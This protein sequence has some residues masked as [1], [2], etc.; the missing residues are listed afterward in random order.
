M[1]KMDLLRLPTGG[2][3]IV[4]SYYSWGY[5]IGFSAI[6]LLFYLPLAKLPELAKT[7]LL[8]IFQLIGWF[9]PVSMPNMT[10]Q[11]FSSPCLFY[12]DLIQTIVPITGLKLLY[13]I[14]CMELLDCCYSSLTS[15]PLC[16][17]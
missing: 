13:G 15:E 14:H 9:L 6:V 10:L 5:Y 3:I 2:I 1:L 16:C 8:L 4:G 17:P 11:Y 7:E 12:W